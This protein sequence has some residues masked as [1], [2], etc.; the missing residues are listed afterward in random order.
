[1]IIILCKNIKDALE[2]IIQIFLPEYVL[3]GMYTV[4]FAFPQLGTKENEG[5]VVVT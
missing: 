4:D 3:H 5:V 1:M 2:V